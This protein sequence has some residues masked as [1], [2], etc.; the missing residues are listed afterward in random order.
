M[1]RRNSVL[2]WSHVPAA[3][4][5]SQPLAA[6]AV[7]S[8]AGMV[9]AV[10]AQASGLPEGRVYERVSAPDKRLADVHVGVLSSDDGDTVVFGSAGAGDDAHGAQGVV[11]TLARRTA[12]GW[13]RQSADPRLLG[14]R[15]DETGAHSAVNLLTFSSDFTRSLVN[16][17]GQLDA[18]D[19]DGIGE[20]LFRLDV[21]TGDG[22]LVS[23]GEQ[24]PDADPSNPFY[25]V[26]ANE[27]LSRVYFQTRGRALRAGA[28]PSAIYEWREDGSVRVASVLPSGSQVNG[29]AVRE[30]E[31][32]GSNVGGGNVSMAHGGARS[33]SRD[34][35]RL[36]FVVGSA[37][38]SA[39]SGN[40]YRREGST[41]V[42]ISVSQRTGSVGTV[43]SASFVHAS[44]DGDTVFFRSTSQLTNDAPAGAGLYRY[45]VSTNT[46]DLISGGMNGLELPLVS[47]DGSHVYFSASGQL[48]PGAQAGA[49]NHYVW[50]ESGGVRFIA[51]ISDVARPSRISR[52][53]RFAL[54]ESYDSLNG[55]PN[56]WNQAIYRYDAEA[57]QI[58][59]ASC[60]PDGEPSQ[61]E[62]FLDRPMVFMLPS[63]DIA[64][65]SRN[66][67]DSGH[68]FFSSSDQ[69]VPGDRNMAFDA[70]MY[71]D[72]Q[73][74][75]L[76]SGRSSQDSVIADSSDDG[77]NVFFT[78]RDA[79][80]PEDD[81]GGSTDLYN[82]RIGGGGFP[83]VPPTPAPCVGDECRRAPS[84]GPSLLRPG[85]T[86]LVGPG[87]VVPP[88]TTARV[89]PR[90]ISVGTLSPAEGR[91]LLRGATARLSVRVRGGGSV[92]V[93]VKGR[94]RG[95]PGT[96][97]QASVLVRKSNAT[98][99]KVP[100]RLTA[101]VRR[102]IAGSRRVPV[103]LE[104]RLSGVKNPVRKAVTLKG[105]AR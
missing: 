57:N 83:V 61:G 82:A 78:T 12:T 33:V 66:V 42:P 101:S 73:P 37:D 65:R 75:L 102:Q 103:R 20:D 77:S 13:Q 69:I 4:R 23:H 5:W 51:A 86:D 14:S 53:G 11:Y 7:L 26:G 71:V 63:P 32:P 97:T 1:M 64:S 94:G 81:D 29:Y 44:D 52:N 27:D 35:S 25:F 96:L 91:K 76:S 46:L 104:V 30:S 98:T 72:G 99:V 60:R 49:T 10:S 92:R 59:C 95:V 56:D 70:Y 89:A 34:G 62:A 18:N 16:T 43:Q 54:Y 15:D 68:V 80:V 93:A 55:A 38:G 105:A 24:L 39:T 87:N 21:A 90:I 84:E 19:I 22:T 45:V 67:S 85:S 40:L 50:T 100:L 2:A 47:A 9:S 6:A 31:R 36:F 58:V 3:R 48:A 28:P 41:T 8:M 17:A 79:L 74:H 88:P